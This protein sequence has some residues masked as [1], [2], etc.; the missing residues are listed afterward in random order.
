M[1]TKPLLFGLIGFFLG[2]LLVSFA[3]TTFDTTAAEM[4]PD[5]SMSQMSESLQNKKG[6]EFDRAYLAEMIAHHEGAVDM[7]RLS[8][9]NAK[10][11]EIKELSVEIIKAQEKEIHDMKHW[12]QDWGYTTS[13]NLAH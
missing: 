13:T 3:A 5:K 4:L 6:D 11:A 8:A 9:Q 2:G 12:Q 10:H 1:E 7:A